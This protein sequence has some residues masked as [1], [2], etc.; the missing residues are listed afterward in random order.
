MPFQPVMSVA[1]GQKGRSEMKLFEIPM[2]VTSLVGLC[3]LAGL[4]AP[5]ARADFTFGEPVDIHSTFPLLKLTGDC[6]NCFSADGLEMYIDSNRSGGYSLWD[7]WVCKRASPEDDWGLPENLG[8][9]VNSASY[10]W[11]SSIS[12]DGLELYFCSMRPGG[13][14]NHDLYV[15]KRTTRDSPWGLPTNLGPNVNNSYNDGCPWVS[16][17][18][19]EL[20]FQ[21]N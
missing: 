11:A 4:D 10:N 17:D 5:P 20:Y 19:L 15:T 9:T 2:V 13:Y 18:G 12:G 8:P 1:F 6:L 16:A 7:L 3:F 21:S 14:G